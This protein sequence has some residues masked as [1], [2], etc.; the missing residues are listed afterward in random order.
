MTTTKHE[1]PG[2][3]ITRSNAAER[4]A[5]DR[6]AAGES[7]ETRSHVATFN[8]IGSARYSVERVERD[9]DGTVEFHVVAGSKRTFERYTSERGADAIR[10]AARLACDDL[11]GELLC[12]GLI[13]EVCERCQVGFETHAGLLQ[14]VRD[15]ECHDTHPCEDAACVSCSCPDC[16]SAAGRAL[17]YR[18]EQ[19]CATCEGTR[20]VR[21]PGARKSPTVS[22]KCEVCEERPA[23]DTIG[24][25][26]AAT[27]LVCREDAGKVRTLIAMRDLEVAITWAIAHVSHVEV[28]S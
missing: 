18:G 27:F 13:G 28:A 9:A 23:V 14:H 11:I 20:F 10:H 24:G 1:E 16:R 6:A 25:G 5:A 7:G 22:G 15:A 8:G 17:G 19:T 21:G 4:A 12:E 2:N 26:A 3:E